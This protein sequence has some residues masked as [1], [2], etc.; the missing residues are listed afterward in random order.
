MSQ[1]FKSAGIPSYSLMQKALA[2]WDCK[3]QPS[4]S[5]ITQGLCISFFLLMCR[6]VRDQSCWKKVDT[7]VVSCLP[8]GWST[9]KIPGKDDS[10]SYFT[11]REQRLH[12]FPA[13]VGS[14]CFYIAREKCKVIDTQSRKP[15]KSSRNKLESLDKNLCK[16]S[17]NPSPRG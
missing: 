4:S 11:I 13:S 16:R 10:S 3:T 15:R 2:L 6:W 8:Q 14:Q 1:W 7:G 9:F 17:W 12:V 5:P